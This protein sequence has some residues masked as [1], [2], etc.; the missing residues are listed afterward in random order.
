MSLHLAPTL[1]VSKSMWLRGMH[2]DK[3]KFKEVTH[4]IKFK[5]KIKIKM[6]KLVDLLNEVYV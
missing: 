2:E 3:F 6:F 4:V 5:I 1:K